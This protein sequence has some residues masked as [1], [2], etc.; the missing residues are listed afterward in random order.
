MKISSPV[1]KWASSSRRS[2]GPWVCS[3]RRSWRC[4][5]W[6]RWKRV[7]PT[8]AL[9]EERT[10]ATT[11][12]K[13]QLPLVTSKKRSSGEKDDPMDP[14]PFYREFKVWALKA[15]KRERNTFLIP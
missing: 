10:L 9:P 14:D 7:S 2:S 15:L 6:R 12:K 1:R 5:P 3:F 13:M 11:T 4:T 8:R